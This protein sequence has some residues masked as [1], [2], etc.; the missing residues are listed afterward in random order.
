MENI[1]EF[2]PDAKIPT[3]LPDRETAN[4]LIESFFTNVGLRQPR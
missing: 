3:Q 1:I 2:P 4:V